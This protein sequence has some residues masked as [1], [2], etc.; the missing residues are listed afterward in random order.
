MKWTASA[1]RLEAAR[2][3]LREAGA[4]SILHPGLR[5]AIVFFDLE[6]EDAGIA[7]AAFRAVRAAVGS[8]G[9]AHATLEQA[10]AWAKDGRDVFDAPAATLPLMRALKAQFDPAGVLNPGRFAGGL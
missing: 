10:P 7:D 2:S 6:Q 3:G 9:G 8:E 4:R 1:S 5:Q